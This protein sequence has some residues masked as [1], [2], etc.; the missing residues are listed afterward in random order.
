MEAIMETVIAL[1]VV[2][3]FGIACDRMYLQYKS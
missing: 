3:A 2:F 1:I